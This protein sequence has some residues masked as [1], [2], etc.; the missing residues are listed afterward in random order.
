MVGR[1]TLKTGFY[2][3]HNQKIQP[4]G[5]GYSGN[6]NFQPDTNNALYNTGN[7]YANALLGY[8]QTATASRPRARC[9]T[10]RYWNFE[11]YVQDNFRVNRKLT[12]DYGM[13]VYHQTPQIDVN[14]T[15]AIF[16]P[17]AVLEIDDAAHLHPRHQRRQARRHRSRQRTPSLRCRT[18]ACSCRT[19]A[20]PATGCKLL[21]GKAT[22][23]S[24]TTS[25]R[26][27]GRPASA[28]PTT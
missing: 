7:G 1:H 9:S 16:D 27:R 5:G 2:L 8:V 28:S 17:D 4:A 26:S 20:I 11:V 22:A 21:D 25:A 12:L 24:P 18:S 10:R 3:E 6:Y 23:A 15:F 14:D 19:P 13:R